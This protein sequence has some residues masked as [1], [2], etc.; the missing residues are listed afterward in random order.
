MAD[1]WTPVELLRHA[2]HD[3]LNQIQLIKANLSMNR[4]ERVKEIIEEMIDASREEA[5][6][7]NLK[8]PKLA[9]Y[10]LLFNWN[11]SS[12]RVRF[13]VEGESAD[14]S[15]QDEDLFQ[16]ISSLTE[17][18]VPHLSGY[19]EPLLQ[20]AIKPSVSQ[21]IYHFQGGLSSPDVVAD[22]VKGCILAHKSVEVIET[23][24]KENEIY[25]CISF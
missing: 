9:Q 20:V 5:K 13:S 10:L 11:E 17:V 25:S 22:K 18:I 21:V 19:D 2:R 15:Q 24:T 4:P 12:L 1:K 7:S 16:L 6:L 23:Y 14:L 3:W 8:A